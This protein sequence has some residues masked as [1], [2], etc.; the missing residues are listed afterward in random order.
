MQNRLL[1]GVLADF[2]GKFAFSS[3]V[4][5]KQF[6]RLV[7]YTVLSKIDPEAFA[8]PAVFEEIDVDSGGTFGIDAFAVIANDSLVT[9]PEDLDIQRRSRRLD[10][11]FVF[12][13]TKLSNGV[14]SG[15]LLKFFAAIKAVFRKDLTAPQTAELASASEFVDEIFKPE[16]SRLFGAVRPT[17]EIYFAYAGRRVEDPLVLQLARTFEVELAQAVGELG[18]VSVRFIDSDYV[19]DAY[20]EIE[21]RFRVTIAFEQNIPC[22]RIEGVEQAYIGFLTAAEFLKLP[23]T[24]S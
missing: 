20:S 17:C 4:E 6:E 2:V 11:R 23:P 12:V 15:D 22:D 5:S 18:G 16:N 7:N 24:S 10:V 19:I 14:D 8:D 9:S 1:Q 21:N 3:L 13:Q